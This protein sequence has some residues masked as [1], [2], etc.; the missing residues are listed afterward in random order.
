MLDAIVIEVS[1]GSGGHGLVSYHREKFVP[2][3]G[4]DGGDGGR[5]GRVFL[6]AVD[7]VYTLE[8]FRSK[9]KFHA[10]DGGNGGPNLRTG[11]YGTDLSLDVPVGTVVH[12]DETDDMVAD[13][14][15]VG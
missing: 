10:G 11:A 6:K 3:G 7:D 9:K 5:G 14:E 13:M 4:P 2:H 8:L 12:D 15:T 1:G